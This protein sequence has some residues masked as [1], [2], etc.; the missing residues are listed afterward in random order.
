[1][2]LTASFAAGWLYAFRS[3]GVNRLRWIFTAA[4]G[5][6]LVAQASLKSGESD[7]PVV[8][9]LAP[10]ILIFGAGL[11]FVLLGSNAVPSQWPRAVT[12]AL[13][14]VQALPLAHDALEP[15]R[16]HFQY[17][18]YFP[19]LFQGMRSELERPRAARAV[20]AHGGCPGGRGVV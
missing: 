13:L 16:L 20:W 4:L 17:P 15:R 6:L 19:A 9:W 10:L 1:M 8:V 3:P 12:A 14:I 18:P 11:F 7:R 2:W 5:V